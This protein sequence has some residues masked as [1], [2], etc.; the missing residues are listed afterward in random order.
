M[1]ASDEEK[2]LAWAAARRSMKAKAAAM[3]KNGGR[4]SEMKASML[5]AENRGGGQRWRE[6]TARY[7]LRQKNGMARR[8]A[9]A[10]GGMGNSMAGGGRR[11]R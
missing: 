8:G 3:K 11:P 7:E 4:R 10:R 9:S 1:K 6:K 5:R 2:S